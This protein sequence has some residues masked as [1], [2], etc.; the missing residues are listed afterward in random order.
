MTI[1][2][3][4]LCLFFGIKRNTIVSKHPT[5]LVIEPV[6]RGDTDATVHSSS[7]EVKDLTCILYAAIYVTMPQTNAMPI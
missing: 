1:N 3:N 4:F 6:T 5:A 7:V 2:T